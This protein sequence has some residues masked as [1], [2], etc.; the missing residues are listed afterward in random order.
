MNMD[1]QKAVL[2]IRRAFSELPPYEVT[3]KIISNI[4]RTKNNKEFIDMIGKIF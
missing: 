4:V 2:S 1:E 3:E